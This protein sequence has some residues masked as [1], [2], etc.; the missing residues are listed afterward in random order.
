METQRAQVP[1]G[2]TAWLALPWAT[3]HYLELACAAPLTFTLRKFVEDPALLAFFASLNTAFTFTVG[4]VASYMSDR[5]WTPWGRRRPFLVVG[6]MGVVVALALIPLAGNLWTL[7]ALILLLHLCQDIAK[8]YE[9]LYNEIVPPA[10][11]GRAGIVRTTAVGLTG[12]VFNAVLFAG[13]DRDYH[14]AAFGGFHVRGEA[15]LYWAGAAFVAMT[16]LLVG[17]RVRE[18][19]PERV[20]HERFELRRFL[21]EVFGQ[22][23][24]CRLYLLFACPFLAGMSFATFV[25]L[26]QTEQLG[27]S[28]S[29]VA[30]AGAIALLTS[31]VC[32]VPLAGFL[33]DRVSR[34]R[35]FQIGLAGPALVNVVLFL[36]VRYRVAPIEY[37][38]LVAFNIVSVGFLAL[39]H[40]A[41]GPLLYDY[42][43]PERFG[44][45][46]AG[47]SVVGGIAGFVL[48][49]AA[50][51]WIKLFSALDGRLA[52]GQFDYSS[53]FIFQLLCT[54]VA[55]GVTVAFQRWV[56][57]GDIVPYA[58]QVLPPPAAG[59][60]P[61][62]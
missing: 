61:T 13:F 15:V 39:L 24:W 4:A 35:L 28:K 58:R 52:Q 60:Y 40:V 14:I 12:L 54:V 11:R 21:R 55:L 56:A 50:G 46:S 34:L 7:A 48:A 1:W 16:V 2:W 57:C 62:N 38:A 44:T 20:T 42:V 30:Y 33:A 51:G 19:L 27:F 18:T 53:I 17:C 23:Q 32:F 6:W 37:P 22:P 31:I 5:I 47:F 36:V 3:L 29:D 43:P 41:W 8:P 9:P 25:P 59:S 10:Q 45:V 49:N 26:F